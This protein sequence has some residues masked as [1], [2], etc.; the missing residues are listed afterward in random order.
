MSKDTIARVLYDK[1]GNEITVQEISG[2]HKISTHDEMLYRL[3][4]KILKEVRMTNYQLAALTD[5]GSPSAND[6]EDD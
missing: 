4:M 6:M 5:I 1:D 2:E 3:L